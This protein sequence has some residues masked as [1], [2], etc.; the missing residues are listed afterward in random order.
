[1]RLLYAY[2]DFCNSQQHPNG[3]R[4]LKQCGLNF[5]TDHVYSVERRSR[6]TSL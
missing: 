5:S 2:F 4:G 3:Y 1:M 6:L